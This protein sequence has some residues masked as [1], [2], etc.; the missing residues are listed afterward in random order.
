[1]FGGSIITAK[2]L[3]KANYAITYLYDWFGSNVRLSTEGDNLYAYIKTDDRAFKFWA[4]QYCEEFRV[5]EPAYL[6]E[7]VLENA[8]KMLEDYKY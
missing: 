3:V 6:K 8:K 4:L 2:V 7:Q 1:M 5:I